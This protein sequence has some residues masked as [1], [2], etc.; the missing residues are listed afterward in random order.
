MPRASTADRRQNGMFLRCT[1]L[2]QIAY[3][4]SCI[5]PLFPVA[6]TD[7]SAKPLI[8]FGYD[9]IVLGYAIVVHPAAQI[10]GKLFHPVLHR[11]KPTATGELSDAP[12]ELGK[13]CIRPADFTTY[14]GKSEEAGLVHSGN[15]AFDL[16]DLEFELAFDETLDGSHHAFTRPLAFHQ[17]DK[18]IGI[19][20]ETM[21]APL[22][23]LVQVI[24]KD[25]G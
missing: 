19:A 6:H 12:F 21:P 16:I 15:L 18:V 22:K 2:K 4:G 24:E 14:N 10:Q 9:P 11:D 1:E 7:S 13:C 5:S 25:V 3:L 20:N 17:N 8:Y 23:L